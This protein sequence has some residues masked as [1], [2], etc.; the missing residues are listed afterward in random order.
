MK[1]YLI[2]MLSV[3]LFVCILSVFS[4][5]AFKPTKQKS[6]K[7]E[8]ITIFATTTAA[9]G[10]TYFGPVTLSGGINAT[11][12]YVMPTKVLGMALHCVFELTLP[13][14]T[15]TIRMN[16]NMMTGNGR[17]KILE[18]TGAYETLTGGG[19]LVMPNDTDEVLTG[20]VRWK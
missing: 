1:R 2:S 11:G 5:F 20:V 4:S 9:E 15:I 13:D 12:T 14:G 19:S 7:S 3:S 10:D 17:W 8:A 16:C 18:G 6:S